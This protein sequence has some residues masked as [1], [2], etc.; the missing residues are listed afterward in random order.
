MV[1][2][3]TSLTSFWFIIKQPVWP[4]YAIFCTLGN[5]LKAVAIII[6]PKSPTLLA[7][8]RKGAKIIHFSSEIIFGQ[9]LWTFGD[10]YLV[11]LQAT[12]I[13]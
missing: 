5:H 2:Y 13:I 7:N 11:T 9:L 10:F 1:K 6:L 12:D 3:V 4:D 8:F